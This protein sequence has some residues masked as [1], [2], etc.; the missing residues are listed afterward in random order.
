LTQDSDF[1]LLHQICIGRGHRL[2]Y[3]GEHTYRTGSTPWIEHRLR[4]P[5]QLSPV[6]KPLVKSSGG[7]WASGV[8]GIVAL[9]E[10]GQHEDVRFAFD[11]PLVRPTQSPGHLVSWVILPG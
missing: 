9:V 8:A 6:V 11:T 1:F 10:P 7:H 3:H 5:A 2:A 4:V